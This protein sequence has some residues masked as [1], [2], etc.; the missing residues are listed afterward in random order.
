[1][2]AFDKGTGHLARRSSC[3][4]QGL[5][6]ASLSVPLYQVGKK[7]RGEGNIKEETVSYENTK[8]LFSRIKPALPV[9]GMERST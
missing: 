4:I 9:V 1:M 3:R 7:H 2:T 5:P 8:A 6:V